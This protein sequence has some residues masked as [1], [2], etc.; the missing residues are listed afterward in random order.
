MN[1]VSASAR[2]ARRAIVPVLGSAALVAA[3]LSTPTAT[4]DE[5]LEVIASG[6]D[7]PRQLS[8]GSKGHLYVAEAGRG[9]S[10]P[11]VGGPEGGPVC[12]GKSGAITR[13]TPKGTQRRTPDEGYREVI[14]ALRAQLPSGDFANAG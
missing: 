1:Q 4:A 11:C 14:R 6:L 5:H 9:G 13:V 7:N 3:S 8:F 12:F 2:V 10:G